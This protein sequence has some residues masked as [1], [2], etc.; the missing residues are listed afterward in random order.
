MNLPPRWVEFLASQGFEAAH[1][2]QVGD[3]R[4]SDHILL[5]WARQRGFVVFTHDLDFSRLLALTHSMGPSVIQVRTEDVLPESIGSIVV[6]A[7][8]QHH[9]VLLAGALAVIDL[10]TTRVRVLPLR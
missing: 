7:L 6:A 5:D 2:S 1:W 3:E 8:R 9:D 10:G 4:A